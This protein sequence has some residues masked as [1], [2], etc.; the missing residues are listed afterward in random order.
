M[1]FLLFALISTKYFLVTACK[2]QPLCQL[3]GAECKRKFKYYPTKSG[4]VTLACLQ[5]HTAFFSM[6]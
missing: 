3:P 4:F 2:Q 5:L 1:L 6:N